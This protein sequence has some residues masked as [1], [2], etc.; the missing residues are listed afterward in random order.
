MKGI[1]Q[2]FDDF[3]IE[4]GLYEEA[5]ELATKRIIALQLE[6]EMKKQNISKSA[7]AEKMHTSRS[8]VDNVLDF[9]HNTS[10]GILERFATAL[11]KKVQINLV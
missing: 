4:Q 1:G 10:I 2:N 9:T 6:E 7:M 3:M 5:Q 8:A 11:G